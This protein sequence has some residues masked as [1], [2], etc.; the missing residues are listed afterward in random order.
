VV[1]FRKFFPQIFDQADCGVGR[2]GDVD[3]VVAAAF[4]PLFNRLEFSGIAESAITPDFEVAKGAD[5]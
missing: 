2:G 5:R 1:R 4:F 3:P